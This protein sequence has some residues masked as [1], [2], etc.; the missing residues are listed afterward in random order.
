MPMPGSMLTVPQLSSQLVGKA[1]SVRSAS[2][3]SARQISG[4]HV[5]GADEVG[6][7]WRAPEDT[8][9]NSL[10]GPAPLP[11]L[12]GA[13]TLLA[14]WIVCHHML[15]WEPAS[16]L[17]P[18]TMRVDVG[19]ECFMLLSGFLT[20]HVF[21]LEELTSSMGSVLRYYA[22]RCGRLLLA[23]EVSILLSIGHRLIYNM[24]GL[25]QCL[26]ALTWRSGLWKRSC[27]PGSSI[28]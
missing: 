13:R 8:S 9:R 27:L 25:I 11:H 20:Q 19:V 15:P 23:T 7:D 17:T 5:E 10:S 16:V 6:G 3:E 22:R 24:P 1:P 4:L 26:T 14:L 12:T 18:L 28:P 2:V 21:G